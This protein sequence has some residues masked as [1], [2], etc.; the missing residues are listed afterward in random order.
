MKN[1]YLRIL[2][3]QPGSSNLV[4]ATVTGS[5][6]STPQKPGSSALFS[7]DGLISGTV[8]GG[9]LEGKVQEF[10]KKSLLSKESGH[11]RF[12]LD[13]DISQK[14]EAICGGEIFVLVDADP[15]IHLSVFK[16][17]EQ[18]LKDR[19]PGVLITLVSVLKENKVLINRYWMEEN[20]KPDLPVSFSDKI[21]PEVLSIL[22]KGKPDDFRQIELSPPDEGPYP[23][24]FLEPVFPLP[25]LVIAGAGHIG[26]ALSH[27]GRMLNFEVTVIDDRQE[28]A[29]PGN[30]P[31]ADHLIVKDIGEAMEEL[32]KT[33]E[34]Y[35]VIVTRGHNDDAKALKPCIGS[36][37]AYAGMIGSKGKV[38]KMH[39]EFIRNTWAT[40]E[41][42]KKIYAPIG[43]DIGSKT[44]EEIAVS[45][46]AQMVLVRNSRK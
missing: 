13:K 38:A 16:E 22:A 14:E 35:V 34:T 44:V 3:M 40:E 32:E 7:R 30:L 10:A 29:N 33:P 41:Q 11:L 31:D 24:I 25:H 37:A 23:L 8:G 20:K 17:I 6:G 9:M 2:E 18:S 46:A 28:Y 5:F 1:I 12:L 26:K 36:H 15:F 27:L 39:D 45:I 19:I 42:W 21:V 4:L 43:L